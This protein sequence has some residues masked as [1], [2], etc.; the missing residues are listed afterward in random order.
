MPSAIRTTALVVFCLCFL[1][2][3]AAGF[4]AVRWKRAA[5]HSLEEW[6]L[7]GRRFGARPR[8]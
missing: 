2:V 5:L 7:A 1:G 4:L 8:N 6:G 3:T